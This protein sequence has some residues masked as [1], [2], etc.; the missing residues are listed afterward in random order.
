ME[1]N[2]LILVLPPFQIFEGA[3]D[4]DPKVGRWCGDRLPPK[5]ESY[6]N[7]LLIV[8]KSDWSAQM[9]GFR[10]AYDTCKFPLSLLLDAT[11]V[12]HMLFI[13]QSF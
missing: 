13:Y 10:I 6:G 4:E 9:E 1:K 2:M 8:F 3:T 5:Y 7:V 11:A 12:F